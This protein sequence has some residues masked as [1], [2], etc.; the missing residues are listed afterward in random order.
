L[1]PEEDAW[2][3]A[4]E[5]EAAG[6]TGVSLL[7]RGEE[8]ASFEPEPGATPLPTSVRLEAMFASV[9]AAERGAAVTGLGTRCRYEPLADRDWV[10]EGRQGFVPQRFGERLWVVPEW[11]RAPD[12]DAIN[13][14]L[15]PGL[16]FGTGMH[17]STALC[18]EWL[19]A[20]D[21]DGR[22]LIAYGC[23]S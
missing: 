2:A 1:E 23:G 22:R 21:L 16:A 4:N 19:A 5:L 20:A 12:P 9:S 6:A 14:F 7:P 13:V 10:A 18:L 15:A 17:P 11:E 8:P 3:V